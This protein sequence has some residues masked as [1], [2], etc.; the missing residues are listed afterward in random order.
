MPGKWHNNWEA[1]FSKEDTEWSYIYK[2]RFG[3]KVERRCDVRLNEKNIVEFQHSPITKEEV[4]NRKANYNEHGKNIIWM[5]DG[6]NISLTEVDNDINNNGKYLLEKISNWMIYPFLIYPFV[7]IDIDGFIFKIRPDFIKTTNMCITSVYK[8]REETINLFKNLKNGVGNITEFWNSWNTKHEKIGK[9]IR[10]QMGAG[11]GK[12]YNLWKTICETTTKSSFLVLTKNG[13]AV[14]VLY[15]ELEAQRK[16]QCAHLIDLIDIQIHPYTKTSST[17][18]IIKY[19]HKKTEKEVIIIIGTIDSFGC[20]LRTLPQNVQNK[21]MKLQEELYNKGPSKMRKNGGIK[22]GGENIKLNKSCQIWIDEAQDLPMNYFNAL[23]NLMI[24]TGID[25]G[26]LGDKMQSISFEQNL[27]TKIK[28]DIKSIQDDIELVDLPPG[29]VNRRIKSK[30]L[31]KVIN[32]IVR[33]EEFGCLPI[34]NTETDGDGNEL[35]DNG[36]REEVFSTFSCPI[37]YGSDSATQKEEKSKRFADI[38]VNIMKNEIKKYFWLPND[39]LINSTIVS[40]KPELQELEAKIQEMWEEI[41]EDEEYRNKIPDDNYWKKNN[42]KDSPNNAV[43]YVQFHRSENG[44]PIKL[45]ES[46]YKTRITSTYTSKGMGR[47]IV[48]SVG[49]TESA[50]KTCANHTRKLCYEALFHVTVT[51]AKTRQYFQLTENNDDIHR[52]FFKKKG[53]FYKPRIRRF[54]N[55]NTIVR[56]ADKSLFIKLLNDNGINEN[57][58]T[59]SEKRKNIDFNHHMTRYSAWTSSLIHKILFNQMNFTEYKT[60]TNGRGQIQTM[61]KFICLPPKLL[62][63]KKYF[64]YLSAYSGLKGWDKDLTAI[65]IL[66]KSRNHAYI[67]HTQIMR[68]HILNIQRN[69][70]NIEKWKHPFDY[71]VFCHL[72]SLIRNKSHA[73]PDINSLYQVIDVFTSNKKEDEKI[74][75]N[76]LKDINKILDNFIE[77]LNKTYGYLDWNIFHK[78]QY[79]GGTDEFVLQKKG[80]PLIGY[81]DSSVVHIILKPTANSINVWDIMVDVLL[82]RFMIFNPKAKDKSEEDKIK[83]R[84]DNYDRYNNKNVKTFVIV[85]ETGEI[86]QIDDNFERGGYDDE[87]IVFLKEGITRAYKL[88]H[89]ELYAYC[90]D[91][92]DHFNDRKNKN[93]LDDKKINKDTDV[94]KSYSTPWEVLL[95]VSKKQNYPLYIIHFFTQINKLWRKKEKDTVRK[96]FD[97]EEAFIKELND[98]LN[99]TLNK[100]FR[101]GNDD[102]TD[103]DDDF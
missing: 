23:V 39:F 11:N 10:V 79:S 3:E 90:V 49:V 93:I 2:S 43:K 73:E 66:Q 25:I 22:Y 28:E 6:S 46:E 92:K 101:I 36:S 34:Q 98:E 51:R 102:D 84:K 30:H 72:L 97:T 89:K 61:C 20:S 100:F 50:L 70:L 15:E 41:M 24:H 69:I 57:I 26:M 76:K 96:F 33:F 38:I 1:E 81:N 52:R 64:N 60:K 44:Q 74:F 85:L 68:N 19:K 7:L 67:E 71:I 59:E 5:L 62:T 14:T 56:D 80:I 94:F 53:V 78:I 48:I 42:H 83:G 16:R 75:F 82:Q 99:A 95:D 87:I 103:D 88:S 47:E 27:F 55:I 63:T 31:A 40:N 21:F 37:I 9:F 77:K 45:S 91:V 86:V 13:S 54:L 12:T 29:N 4:K 65:P 8:T 32:E 18:Y 58:F 17:K 35:Q